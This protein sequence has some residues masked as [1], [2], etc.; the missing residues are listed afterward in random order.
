MLVFK[1]KKLRRYLVMSL[2]LG[3]MLDIGYIR[4]EL[5]PLH[6]NN[7]DFESLAISSNT[8]FSAGD[9]FTG[10]SSVGSGR[11]L[12]KPE[13]TGVSDGQFLEL[14][15]TNGVVISD[16]LQTENGDYLIAVGDIITVRFRQNGD[17]YERLVEPQLYY[18]NGS[19]RTQ[20]VTVWESCGFSGKKFAED[21][22]YHYKVTDSSAVG[23]TLQVAFG[24]TGN[25]WGRID[26]VSVEVER[27]TVVTYTEKSLKC[28]KDGS[29][30]S[31][32]VDF[33]GLNHATYEA[34]FKRSPGSITSDFGGVVMTNGFGM[35]IMP[36]G[37]LRYHWNDSSHWGTSTGLIVPEGEWVYTALVI[38]PDKSSF[39]LFT[40]SKGWESKELVK[41]HI[42]K[43]ITNLCVGVQQTR[44]DRTFKA[45]FD[46]VRFWTRALTESQ[47]KYNMS[48][49]KAKVDGAAPLIH[50][51]YNE[52]NSSIVSDISGNGNDGTITGAHTIGNSFNRF[53]SLH[54][55]GGGQQH[56]ALDYPI[57]VNT[58]WTMEFY[59]K[60][61]AEPA[62]ITQT[63][64]THRAGGVGDKLGLRM[65]TWYKT[66]CVGMT[67]SGVDRDFD[68]CAPVDKWCHYVFIRRGS[69]LELIVDGESKGVIEN[70]ATDVILSS[71]GAEKSNAPWMELAT[72][73]LWGRALSTEE[74]ET[75][76]LHNFNLEASDLDDQSLLLYYNFNHQPGDKVLDLSMANNTGTLTNMPATTDIYL[77]SLAGV[78]TEIAV[79]TISD[80]ECEISWTPIPGVAE[81]YL[82]LATDDEFQDKIVGYDKLKIDNATSIQVVSQVYGLAYARVRARFSRENE[83]V[84]NSE[85]SAYTMQSF[86]LGQK[87]SIFNAVGDHVFNEEVESTFSV[88]PLDSYQPVSSL[89]YSLVNA[90]EGSSISPETGEF[91][92]TPSEEQDGIYEF[93]VQVVDG[94]CVD[95]EEITVTVNEVNK[96]APVIQPVGNKVIDE[97]TE[98]SF[99]VTA[100]DYDLPMNLT[101]SLSRAPDG[102]E[103]D[104]ETGSF[105]W[106]PSE[107]QVGVYSFEIVVSDG[108]LTDMEEVA[109]AVRD[110]IFPEGMGTNEDPFQIATSSQLISIGLD[111][112]YWDKHFVVVENID[113]T[114]KTMTPIGNEAAKFTG[115][116]DGDNFVISNLTVNRPSSYFVGLFG[117]AEDSSIH[118]VWLVGV[119]I[120]GNAVVGGLVG[121]CVRSQINNC[122]VTGNITGDYIT[123]GHY[124]AYNIGGL[125][126]YAIDSELSSCSSTG[127]VAG[128]SAVGGLVG[129]SEEGGLVI[130]CFSTSSVTGVGNNISGLVGTNY[131]SSISNSSS[132]GSIEGN[133]YVGGLVGHNSASLISNS[134]TKS[135]VSGVSEVGGLVGSN[136]NNSVLRN[137]Y[138]AGK[139][140][141]I[142]S[143]VGALVGYE[144]SST[145]DNC[146]WDR[147]STG[148]ITSVG[149]ESRYG[150]TTV[151]FFTKDFSSI[152]PFGSSEN[153]P[154]FDEGV[155]SYPELYGQNVF[156]VSSSKTNYFSTL[157]KGWF[158]VGQDPNEYGIEISTNSSF[159]NLVKYDPHSHMDG[160]FTIPVDGLNSGT[161]YYYRAYT[162]RGGI[163]YYGEIKQFTTLPL[164]GLL[165]DTEVAR[166]ELYQ[167]MIEVGVDVESIED[168]KMWEYQAAI[169][170]NIDYIFATESL[171]DVVNAV[172]SDFDILFYELNHGWNLVHV[173]TIVPVDSY[174]CFE[175][176]AGL[177]W[178]WD[179]DLGSYKG[180]DTLVHGEGSWIYW[181]GES[182]NA[183]VTGTF[184]QPTRDVVD[185]QV[186]WNLIGTL[187]GASLPSERIMGIWKWDSENENYVPVVLEEIEDNVGYWIF[188][189]I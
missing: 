51:N 178:V 156:T 98:L 26:S 65:G 73:R 49:V 137:C 31:T 158:D 3:T 13:I 79:T 54:F 185:L 127:R 128:S 159:L 189:D 92:W 130:N 61:Y 88:L 36:S 80:T 8:F 143:D 181:D 113:M 48:R 148:Q 24:G 151:E 28:T 101:F 177:S 45:E 53:N 139:V 56:I 147:E 182:E 99:L 136:W 179:A 96:E 141:A 66:R 4:A 162:V 120:M 167:F 72:M 109:V 180:V 184:A 125:I 138:A 121:H 154:W 126:G 166:G 108:F 134:F 142:S 35:H 106:V 140:T 11:I 97:M 57:E 119:D 43:N 103:I 116:F 60:R 118:N 62:S 69:N 21:T 90:P 89:T 183:S 188:C 10:W 18:S 52:I 87:T 39:Y 84:Y 82:D 104:S 168:E 38:E 63:T 153:A 2:L 76:S 15:P 83:L 41:N 34:W 110:T 20:F 30:V 23:K 25:G 176:L 33:G 86:S 55:D 40:P 71:I 122:H 171:L 16:V 115:G 145:V 129:S 85:Y 78:D 146:Y 157:V 32:N 175:N 164:T 123:M 42:P 131:Q 9:G 161:L 67:G 37:E 152:W 107:D 77:P 149:S 100:T 7:G 47:L 95:Y 165:D 172:N 163:V 14:E 29:Y 91:T 6:V 187:D 64:L 59:I 111:S 124:G 44:N 74:I 102:A 169:S 46:E 68:F 150:L 117:Y 19:D 17:N 93:I 133:A 27:P 186:G 81:Y 144:Y 174:D 135:S 170:K 12:L 75:F 155:Q 132:S 160:R 105:T 5:I 22:V 173:P 1:I 114:N 50:Y 58:D 112:E 70:E 94:G